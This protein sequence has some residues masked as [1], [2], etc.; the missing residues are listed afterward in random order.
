M[1]RFI[2]FIYNTFCNWFESGYDTESDEEI[3]VG[4][5]AFAVFYINIQNIYV[6]YI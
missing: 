4:I 3:E 6:I 1:E 5:E 2:A